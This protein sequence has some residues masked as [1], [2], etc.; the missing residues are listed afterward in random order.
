MTDSDYVYRERA[1]LCANSLS[2]QC[3]DTLNERVIETSLIRLLVVQMVLDT[4]QLFHS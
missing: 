2:S 3:T 1:V 4:T